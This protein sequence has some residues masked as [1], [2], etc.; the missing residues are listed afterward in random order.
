MTLVFAR[1]LKTPLPGTAAQ[2]LGVGFIAGIG[3]TMSLF[4]GALAFPDP[5]MA[6]PV[7]MGV[8]MGSL[9]AALL[10]LVILARTLPRTEARPSRAE[11]PARPFIAPEVA[12]DETDDPRFDAEGRPIPSFQ[13]ES[14]R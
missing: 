12:Y 5:A 9:T 10:G 3:F 4:I 13:A 8:Y 14:H 11:D 7:R 2:I 1:M 6:A